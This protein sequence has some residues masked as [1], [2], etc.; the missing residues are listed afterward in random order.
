MA[1]CSASSLEGIVI[2]LGIQLTAEGLVNRSQKRL[3][4]Q[5]N[6]LPGQGL[7]GEEGK[8]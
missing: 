2:E 4:A 1:I 6:L 3:T 5:G 8:G 7:E